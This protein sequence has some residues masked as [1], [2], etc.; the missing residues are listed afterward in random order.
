MDIYHLPMKMK[1]VILL[2]FVLL[3]NFSIASEKVLKEDWQ[4]LPMPEENKFIAVELTFSKMDFDHLKQGVIPK[5]MEDKWFIYSEG[6][7][8]FF[9]RSWTGIMI[10]DCLFEERGDESIVTGFF[11]NRD[12]S[13]Y[14]EN[15]DECDIFKLYHLILNFSCFA[16]P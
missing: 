10:Y 1:S 5:E 9:Y 2:F 14:T 4:T 12:P 11:V 16:R 3:L 15:L 7:H 6:N 13:Q 8:I